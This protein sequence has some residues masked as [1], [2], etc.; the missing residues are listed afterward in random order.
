MQADQLS[1]FDAPAPLPQGFEYRSDFLSVGEQE[2]LVQHL[3]ALPFKEFE[4]QGFVGKRR[5]ASFGWKYDFNA[6]RLQPAEAMPAFILPIRER[7]ARTFSIDPDA[8]QQLL[9]TEYPAGATIGWHKDRPHFGDVVGIS[10]LS[11]CTFR[12]RR[13]AG[14]RWER[15]SIVA[16]PGSAYLLR[17]PAREEWEHSIPAVER[18]RYS[19]TFRTLRR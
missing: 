11:A 1:F 15:A 9:V 10:L 5:V 2:A 8:L 6:H 17:G 14:S 18:L 3:A 13:S 12:F 16:E 7:A 19:L 4:Y